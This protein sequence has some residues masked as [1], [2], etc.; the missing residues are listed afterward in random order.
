M[1]RWR[2]RGGGRC[3]ELVAVTLAFGRTRRHSVAPASAMATKE[4]KEGKDKDKPK[5]GAL[6]GDE[7]APLPSIRRILNL[8]PDLRWRLILGFVS[9]CYLH[10]LSAL[11]SAVSGIN[12]AS[13]PAFSIV[14]GKIISTFYEVRLI[15]F[16][17]RSAIDITIR[18]QRRYAQTSASIRWYFSVWAS[19][20]SSVRISRYDASRFVIC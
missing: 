10:Q 12:G 11:T 20:R 19:C 4:A 8:R 15:P 5:V 7:Q 16:G 17:Y 1:R 6:G 14:L 3:V 2:C 9:M 18:M 13:F